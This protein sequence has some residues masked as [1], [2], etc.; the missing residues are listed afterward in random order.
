MNRV[1]MTGRV[2]AK[3]RIVYTP[4]GDKFMVFPLRVSEGNFTIDVECPGS[5]SEPSIDTAAGSTVMIS[6]MLIRKKIA[7]KEIVKLKAHKIF[8]MEE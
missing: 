4:R 7:A 2:E 3:P 6:G 5:S 1:F 8:W